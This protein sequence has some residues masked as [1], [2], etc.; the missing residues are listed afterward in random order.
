MG[1]HLS[2]HACL[3]V[4]PR[5]EECLSFPHALV[6]VFVHRECP[7]FGAVQ[8]VLGQAELP[9]DVNGFDAR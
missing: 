4:C 9:K 8:D 5:S 1:T 6:D 3:D 7:T 2:S